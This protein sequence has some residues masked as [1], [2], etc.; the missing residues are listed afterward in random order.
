MTP[1]QQGEVLIGSDFNDT[2]RKI[3][4]EELESHNQVGDMWI[5]VNKKVYDI[6]SWADKH[7]GGP[8]TLSLFAG[9]EAT[10]A[11]ES[12]HKSST[13]NYLGKGDVKYIGDLI[14]TKFPVYTKKTEFYPSLKREIEETFKKS[15]INPKS[16]TPTVFLNTIFIIGGMIMSYYISMFSTHHFLTRY[17]FAILAGLFHHLSMVHIWHD[18]SHYCYSN[19]PRVW[20]YMGWFGETLIGHSMYL[21][22]HRHTATHHIYTNVAGIDPDIGI[23]KCSPKEPENGFKYRLREFIVPTFLQPYLY[24]FVVL[25]MQIDDVTSFRRK[26]MENTIINDTGLFQKTIFYGNKT[27]FLLHRLVLPFIFGA[28]IL[29]TLFL[30]AVTEA[31]AGALF[32]YFSQITHVQ[33]DVLWVNQFNIEED[34]AETQVMTAIDY[35]QDSYFWT[36]ISGNLNYQVVH[37]LFPSIAPHKYHTIYEIVLKKINEHKIKYTVMDNV[38]DVIDGHFN[39]L[40]QFQALKKKKIIEEKNQTRFQRFVGFVRLMIRFFT[41]R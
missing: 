35:C 12:Y 6:T 41:W 32:G 33:E 7:P 21:W 5:S 13:I 36:Y 15:K 29:Q 28:S 23:Y 2:T 25:Q 27:I 8:D 19:S 3:S 22:N 38:S 10:E 39:H 26:K 40:K 4:W 37:H 17:L 18:V 31:V 9:R 1:K 16:I 20:R 24:F 30:F 14:S 11:F 34:W